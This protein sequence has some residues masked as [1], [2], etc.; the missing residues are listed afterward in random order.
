MNMIQ[1]VMRYAYPGGSGGKLDIRITEV[2]TGYRLEFEDYGAGIAAEVEKNMFEPFVTSARGKGGTGLGL[3]ISHNIV[4]N[5]L[6]GAIKVQ[7]QRGS[8]TKFTIE[9]PRVVPGEPRSAEQGL[10]GDELMHK[11]R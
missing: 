8:G 4:T 1:N 3:A 6:R 7:S 2:P 11:R 5:L 10:R 9:V